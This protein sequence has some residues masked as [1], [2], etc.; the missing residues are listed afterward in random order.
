MMHWLM[1]TGVKHIKKSVLC[2]QG[3]FVRSLMSPMS[4]FKLIYLVYIN[5]CHSVHIYIYIYIYMYRHKFMAPF[6][7]SRY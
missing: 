2:V 6:V 1:L 5:L 4:G 7:L 3:S